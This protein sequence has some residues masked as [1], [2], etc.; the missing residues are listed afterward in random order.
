MWQLVRDV[1]VGSQSRGAVC[2]SLNRGLF[3][4]RSIVSA[5]ADASYDALV[6]LSIGL[7]LSSAFPQ[8]VG[9]RL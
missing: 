4:L 1:A 8:S 7:L 3:P 9:A 2:R 5:D 6:Q